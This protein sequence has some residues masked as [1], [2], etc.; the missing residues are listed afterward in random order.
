M[1][2]ERARAWQLAEHW[3]ETS[4]SEKWTRYLARLRCAIL[5]EAPAFF[6]T[7]FLIY[8]MREAVEAD[9][10]ENGTEYNKV[11]IHIEKE[12]EEVSE[13]DSQEDNDYASALQG[14]IQHAVAGLQG[15]LKT[16][17]PSEILSRIAMLDLAFSVLYDAETRVW[18]A[19]DS[20]TPTVLARELVERIG[21]D[22]GRETPAD[23]GSHQRERKERPWRAARPL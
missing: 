13:Q 16:A 18:Q 20:R 23:E 15:A 19:L 1:E 14:F 11:V 2:Y 17:D 5:D 10:W 22:G 21:V 6:R 7:K 4:P 3:Q 8:Q 9:Y 12:L